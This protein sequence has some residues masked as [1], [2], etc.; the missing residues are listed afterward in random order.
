MTTQNDGF[1]TTIN[2][3]FFLRHDQTTPY[4]SDVE[5]GGCATLTDIYTAQ[6]EGE[7]AVFVVDA[8]SEKLPA[9]TAPT[10]Y[11]LVRKK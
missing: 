10:G 9:G 5:G 6:P 4:P 3:G 11:W 2:D 1:I 8:G 7:D